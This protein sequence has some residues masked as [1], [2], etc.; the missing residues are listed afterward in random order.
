MKALKY[1]IENK[2]DDEW[3]DAFVW[4]P[5]IATWQKGKAWMEGIA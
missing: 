4:Q 3:F 5:L 1:T 2:I